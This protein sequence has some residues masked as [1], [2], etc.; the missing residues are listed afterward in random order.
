MIFIKYLMA[1][2]IIE[3]SPLPEGTTVPEIREIFS[4]Y[5]LD[6]V[7]IHKGAAYLLFTYPSEVETLDFTFED[8]KVGQLNNA[9]INPIMGEFTWPDP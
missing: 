9:L 2:N 4:A 6:R 7:Q 1:S 3:V 5:S 8:F